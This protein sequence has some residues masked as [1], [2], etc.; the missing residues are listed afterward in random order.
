MLG[1]DGAARAEHV[2]QLGVDF[3]HL[4]VVH[5][6]VGV[7]F[8]CREVLV[9][10]V[11]AECGGEF[12]FEVGYFGGVFVVVVLVL[13]IVRGGGGVVCYDFDITVFFVGLGVFL[14]DVV[15]IL[16]FEHFLLASQT[17]LCFQDL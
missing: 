8:R 11:G 12:G 10:A 9:C 13:F 17:F 16:V 4:V 15:I 3:F 5:V 6:C 2:R 7:G 14:L 1:D